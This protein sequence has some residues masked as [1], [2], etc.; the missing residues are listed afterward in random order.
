VP[1]A[2]F[3]VWRLRGA[4]GTEQQAV[5]E[6]LLDLRGWRALVEGCGLRVVSVEKEPWHTKPAAPGTR[7]LRTVARAVIPLR[8]TYQFNL[9]CR[10][11]AS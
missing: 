1:N 8:W 3:I 7:A 10:R 4:G 9:I 11:S 5:Q 6:L 2:D